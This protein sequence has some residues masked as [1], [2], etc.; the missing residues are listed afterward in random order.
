MAPSILQASGGE[1]W[2]LVEEQRGVLSRRQLM[3]LGFS[4]DAIRH[5]LAAGRLHFVYRG[6]YAVGR[7]QVSRHGRWVA[8]L[9]ACGPGAVLSHQSVAELLGIRRARPGPIHVSVPAHVLRRVPGVEVH[10]RAALRVATHEGIPAT[11]PADTL[12]DLAVGLPRAALE[13]AI[14][15]ADKHDLIDP[16]TLREVLADTAPRPGVRA[17]RDLLDRAT[18]RLTDSELERYFLRVVR[19]VGL[20]VPE[21]GAELGGFSVDFFCPGLGLV[22]ET[23]GLRYHRTPDAQAK[24]RRRD[25]THTA[26]GLTPVR[27]THAQIRFEADHVEAILATIARRLR[28]T[29]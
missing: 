23:D 28:G 19:R 15:E 18:F 27:F 25:Q 5:R 17:L 3:A 20:P 21:T 4:A 11:S 29:S 6:V 7:P 14:N 2:R 12:I 1:V 10:R 16:E 8:A 9:L 22:V 24:D 13:T 26:A